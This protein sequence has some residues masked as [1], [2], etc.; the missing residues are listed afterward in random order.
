MPIKILFLCTA[1]SA[2]S[3]LFAATLNHLGQD[4]FEAHS[5]GSQAAGFVNPGTPPAPDG[6]RFREVPT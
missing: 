1:N 6:A 2:R 5:A 4:R 3:I